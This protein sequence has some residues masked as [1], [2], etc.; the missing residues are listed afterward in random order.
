MAYTTAI[1]FLLYQINL[2]NTSLLKDTILWFCFTGIVTAFNFA[3]SKGSQNLF[4]KVIA[5]NFKLVVIITFLVNT[6]TFSLIGELILI[7]IVTSIILFG[8]VAEIK[9]YPSVAKLMRWLQIIIGGLILIYAIRN[10]VSDYTNFASFDMLRKFLLPILLSILFLPFIYFLKL[11]ATYEILFVPLKL[12]YEKSN[13]L[14]RYAKWKIIKYCR[15]SLKKVEKASNMKI[16]NLMHIK[17]KDDV[18]EIIKVYK[19]QV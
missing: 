17:S 5:D 19:S 14:K 18:D 11:F 16:H 6:Y 7:P 1:V 4:K 12:G 13:K 9:K 8:T 10:V 3:T 15:L 2:W